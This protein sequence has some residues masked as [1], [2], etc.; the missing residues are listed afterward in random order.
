MDICGRVSRS[1]IADANEQRDWRI[2]DD[3]AHALITVA[4][5]ICSHMVYPDLVQYEP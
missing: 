1:T 2:Y 4:R 3:L 5:M